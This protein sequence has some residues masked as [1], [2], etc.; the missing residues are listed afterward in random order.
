MYHIPQM[1]GIGFSPGLAQRL[2]TNFP[3]IVVAYKDSF[4]DFENTK[5]I[6]AAAPNIAVF[7]GSETF[8]RAG[9]ENGGAGCIS[10]TCNVNAAAIRHVYDVAIGDAKGD[11]TEVNDQLVAFRKHIEGYAP[12]PAMKGLL[13]EKRGDPRWRNVRPPLLPASEAD[14]AALIENLGDLS[15]A[16]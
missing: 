9:M 15:G 8:L 11:L 7:T 14:T 13:A 6:I 5:N 12:I 1:A 3:E 10:A 4:G 2:A 16:L